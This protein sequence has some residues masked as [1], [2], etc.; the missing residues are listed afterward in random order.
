MPGC[1]AALLTRVQVSSLVARFQTAA[2]HQQQAIRRDKEREAHL[3]S[4]RSSSSSFGAG[5]AGGIEA[6][7]QVIGPQGQGTGQVP[8]WRAGLRSVS[9]G[10]GGNGGDGAGGGSASKGQSG[11]AQA[12]LN[13]PLT[14]KDQQEDVE[15]VLDDREQLSGT[16]SKQGNGEAGQAED[17]NAS[18]A[19]A[20]TNGSAQDQKN[21]TP[22]SSTIP[23][24]LGLRMS[25]G[26]SK[27]NAPTIASVPAPSTSPKSPKTTKSRSDG[28]SSPT[29][30]KSATGGNTT[31]T[32][33]TV[34][35]SQV[36]DA[37][38]T[39]RSRPSRSPE[40]SLKPTPVSSIR[41]KAL[42][43]S[44]TGLST[45]PT[46]AGAGLSPSPL[47]PQLTG[48]PTRPTASSLA[49]ARSLVSPPP[50]SP[51][52]ST[53]GGAS[54]KRGPSRRAGVTSPPSAYRPG[55]ATNA[56]ANANAG[57][58]AAKENANGTMTL[59]RKAAGRMSMP[60]SSGNGTPAS[61]RRVS[62]G[63][64]GS[65]AG[66]A[67]RARAG[68][69][70]TSATPA[71]QRVRPR[72]SLGNGSS[73]SATKPNAVPATPA[74]PRAR[75]SMGP[76]PTTPV[77]APGSR[78]LQ[79]TASSRA[80]AA[81]AAATLLKESKESGEGKEGSPKKLRAKVRPSKGPATLPTAA[82]TTDDQGDTS[83]AS[84]VGS[85]AALEHEKQVQASAE[86][87]K[88]DGSAE[89]DAMIQQ[90]QEEA[91][92]KAAQ[93]FGKIA[94][95]PAAAPVP[96]AEA[97]ATNAPKH[98]AGGSDAD[99]QAN[100]AL[101][102]EEQA[103]ARNSADDASAEE[104]ESGVSADQIETQQGD[105]QSEQTEPP[106]MPAAII[107]RLGLPAVHAPEAEAAGGDDV[108]PTGGLVASAQPQVVGVP[109]SSPAREFEET[110][111]GLAKVAGDL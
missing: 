78:L 79:G 65:S 2:D 58:G 106:E 1:L 28:P 25:P 83:A 85:T 19:A 108:Q 10:S 90:R 8:N 81:G 29:A 80:K 6:Q 24:K 104:Q 102:E 17:G 91:P 68:S 75:A 47:K 35:A 111:S 64:A 31:T 94:A 62:Q 30:S 107:G 53:A 100:A 43:P 99:I 54:A 37:S 86:L 42:T 96:A 16:K 82:S 9:G 110:D 26:A 88:Q 46:G 93:F 69:S 4:R 89:L 66:T 77:T 7:A 103:E 13:R 67:P 21:E 12:A 87:G 56:G 50:A 38:A 61:A 101:A 59:G 95:A 44:H 34:P 51:S 70:A 49:K 60:P 41:T 32:S 15:E 33:P 105:S 72:T 97:G 27:K 52:P 63:D 92:S 3:S 36:G 109:A 23:A 11:A 73:S 84:A 71:A 18:S 98:E 48:T 14:V 40:S 76:N 22:E 5:G 45:T 20:R 57:P 39:P 55:T 74:V